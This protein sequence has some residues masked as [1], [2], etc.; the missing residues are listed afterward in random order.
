MVVGAGGPL[1]MDCITRVTAAMANG[2]EGALQ[3]ALQ[4]SFLVSADMAH[5]L[6]PNYADKCAPSDAAVS[7]LVA[8]HG[9]C[10][11]RLQLPDYIMLER[12]MQY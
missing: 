1:M 10:A 11:P 9:R 6:H 2:E 8:A 3:R 5:A 7:V 12:I 4:S